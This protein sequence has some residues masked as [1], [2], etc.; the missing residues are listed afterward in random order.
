MGRQPRW[1]PSPLRS[2]LS[3]GIL[4][5]LFPSSSQ[6]PIAIQTHWMKQP[7]VRQVMKG[8]CPE[9]WQARLPRR[10]IMRLISYSTEEVVIVRGRDKLPWTISRFFYCSPSSI[11]SRVCAGIYLS[12]TNAISKS[13]T[14]VTP[15]VSRGS[16]PSKMHPAQ[17]ADERGGG[18]K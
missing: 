12:G 5:C 15:A 6:P 2:A 9:V 10:L 18:G 14:P 17:A 13:S 16:L 8:L 7:F 11:S 3:S 4:C 1:G